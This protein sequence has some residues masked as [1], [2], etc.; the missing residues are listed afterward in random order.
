MHPY[1]NFRI[2]RLSAYMNATSFILGTLVFLL[3]LATTSELVMV[4]G[5]LF[6]AVFTCFNFFAGFVTLLQSLAHFSS[7]EQFA[8]S[9][10]LILLNTLVLI[11]YLWLAVAF[12]SL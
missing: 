12:D 9:L 2:T 4:V 11:G 5:M 6:F 7:F 10:L 8:V 3:F 1:F